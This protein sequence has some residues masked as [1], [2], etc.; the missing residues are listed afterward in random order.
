MNSFKSI[1]TVAVLSVLV[2]IT[3]CAAADYDIRGTWDYVMTDTNQNTYDEG[4]ITFKGSPTQG[5]YVQFNIYDVDYDGEYSVRGTT[6][7]LTGDESW[8]ADI[9]GCRPHH[10]H[11]ESRRR[12]PKRYVRSCAFRLAPIKR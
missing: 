12:R 4:T 5:A 1:L 10:R 11:V 8:K 3:A 6:L 9:T 2:L 7:V